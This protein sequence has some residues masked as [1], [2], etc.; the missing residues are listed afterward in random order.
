MEHF[1][2]PGFYMPLAMVLVVVYIALDIVLC[3]DCFEGFIARL[4]Q[5]GVVASLG[6]KKIAC[7]ELAQRSQPT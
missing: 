6:R 5:K 1:L 3:Q 7:P 2:A 4:K